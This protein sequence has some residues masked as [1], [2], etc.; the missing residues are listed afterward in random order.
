MRAVKLGI[1]LA[2]MV[3]LSV[4]GLALRAEA[5]GFAAN[6][7][8][9]LKVSFV[10]RTGEV[11]T[12]RTFDLS[13]LDALPQSK[14][15]TRTPWTH[16]VQDF[17]GPSIAELA[18]LGPFPVREVRAYSL[19]DWSATIPL[20]DWQ[21]QTV[22]LASRLNGAT[23]RVRDKGPYWIMYP[24]DG[25]RDLDAQMYQAR[26]IWQVKALEFVVE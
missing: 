18:R 19:G 17:T 10:K 4:C 7:K 26:M 9:P 1:T 13:G 20:S 16:G 6:A 8:Y 5:Q 12:E 24:I 22:I 14:I 11:L 15:L 21:R 25:R 2:I 23:M 3:M